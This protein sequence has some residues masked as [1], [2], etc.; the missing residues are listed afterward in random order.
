[1][2]KSGDARA[3]ELLNVANFF[4]AP[5]G[6][7]ENLLLSYG[8]EGVDFTRDAQGNPELTS[9]GEAELTV[10]WKYITAPPQALYNAQYPTYVDRAHEDLTKLI[11]MV[12][13][14]P[15]ASLISP[16]NDKSGSDIGQ[17]LSDVRND[18]IAGRKPISAFDA[19]LAKWK[20]DGGDKI[21]GEFESA[22]GGASP[23]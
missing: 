2:K 16:T 4:A 15:T 23:R 22:L 10:P 21:R 6:S 11:G 19:A 7:T 20:K 9:K 17:A 5:F 18:V 8:V 3:K 13:K 1:M 14:D 12:V